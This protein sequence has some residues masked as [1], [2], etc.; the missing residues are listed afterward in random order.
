M[1]NILSL[2]DFH[3]IDNILNNNV[4]FFFNLRINGQMIPF[5]F[6]IGDL[7]FKLSL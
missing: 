7:S 3:G 4:Y 1:Y 2:Y 6:C 5:R